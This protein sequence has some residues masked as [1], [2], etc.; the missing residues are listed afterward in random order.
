M[1]EDNGPMSQADIDALL[2]ALAAGASNA[3]KTDPPVESQGVKAPETEEVQTAIPMSKPKPVAE[4]LTDP[5][6]RRIAALPMKFR[7]VLGHE[8]LT[9]EQVLQL[10]QNSRVVLDGKWQEPV[11]LTLNGRI[12]GTGNVVLVGNRFG[13]QVVQWGMEGTGPQPS[14]PESLK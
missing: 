11:A 2:A 14:K 13:V 9:M 5:R 3:P 8:T 7:V 12:V 6:L 1:T 10:G 4:R